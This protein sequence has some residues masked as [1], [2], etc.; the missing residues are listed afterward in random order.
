MADDF[1]ENI[2]KL[3]ENYGFRGGYM[4]REMPVIGMDYSEP[5]PTPVEA[6]EGGVEAAEEEVEDKQIMDILNDLMVAVQGNPEA[7]ELVSKAKDVLTA[8][9]QG[10]LPGQPGPELSQPQPEPVEPPQGEMP[11][12]E[13]EQ[14]PVDPTAG[15]VTSG[16]TLPMGTP[17]SD[18]LSY[19][20]RD[21]TKAEIAS[22]LATIGHILQSDRMIPNKFDIPLVIKYINH[23]FSTE[24]PET[25]Q[26]LCE[27][28]IKK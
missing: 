22:I 5:Q 27:S 11:I 25:M 13:V 24:T 12:R 17:R 10:G 9:G 1:R 6:P 2:K 15:N 8:N 18:D 23:N 21:D 16:E 4:N 14:Q 7:T 26:G 28:V 3:F 20:G 19:E